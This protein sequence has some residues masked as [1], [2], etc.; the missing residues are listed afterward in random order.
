MNFEELFDGQMQALKDCNYPPEVVARLESQR[1][2]V[3]A[4][5]LR[6]QTKEKNLP[7][8]AVIPYDIY[9]FEAKLLIMQHIQNYPVPGNLYIIDPSLI[10]D[11][12]DVPKA[13]YFIFDVDSGEV[14]AE[15]SVKEGEDLVRSRG[16]S[17]LTV[18]ETLAFAFH[19][20]ILERIWKKLSRVYTVAVGSRFI[21]TSN[22][23]DAPQQDA[24]F[25][26][27]SSYQVGIKPSQAHPTLPQI[28]ESVLAELERWSL[29]FGIPGKRV[30]RIHNVSMNSSPIGNL[31]T[32]SCLR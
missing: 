17:S 28:P 12:I 26:F 11:I 16:R 13:P 19:T 10:I 15:K 30:P 23:Q 25:V 2:E 14:T 4:K 3:L 20:D 29:Y 27:A 8:L 7:F 32:P 1:S 21:Y 18:A 9:P 31:Q 5:A 22:Q 24:P 6:M